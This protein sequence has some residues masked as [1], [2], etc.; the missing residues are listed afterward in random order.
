[1]VGESS[2]EPL[3]RSNKFVHKGIGQ[4]TLHSFRPTRHPLARE[5]ARFVSVSRGAQRSYR[6]SIAR[7]W[8]ESLEMTSV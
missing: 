6:Q 2:Q 7:I 1:M 3:T 5:L 8:G 4:R